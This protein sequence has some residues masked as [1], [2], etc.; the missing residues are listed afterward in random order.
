METVLIIAG[1]IFFILASAVISLVS[2]FMLQV[3]VCGSDSSRDL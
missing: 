2:F 3:D 1:F